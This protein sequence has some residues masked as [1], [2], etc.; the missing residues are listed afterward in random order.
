MDLP[1]DFYTIMFIKLMLAAFPVW[2][3]RWHCNSQTIGDGVT[4]NMLYK[5]ITDEACDRLP[6]TTNANVTLY[7]NN[8]KG[9]RNGQKKKK[10]A[11]DNS[12]GNSNSSGGG[13]D[14]KLLASVTT[15]R[16]SATKQ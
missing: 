14:M 15:I 11:Q 3:D 9:N 2:V 8:P 7:T 16:K 5:D 6:T 10:D 1:H 4:L 13:S 12:S